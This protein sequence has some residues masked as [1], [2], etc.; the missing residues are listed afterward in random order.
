MG[1]RSPYSSLQ[2]VHD[3]LT[4]YLLMYS[5]DGALLGGLRYAYLCEKRKFSRVLNA[6]SSIH[7]HGYGMALYTTGLSVLSKRNAMLSPDAGSVI[8]SASHIWTRLWEHPIIK[9]RPLP[10]AYQEDNYN[11]LSSKELHVSNP[12]IPERLLNK[13]VDG[14]PQRLREF[15]H[16]EELNP[17]P[18]NYGY[19]MLTDDAEYHLSI[20]NIEFSTVTLEDIFEFENL[21]GRH[22]IATAKA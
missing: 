3:D 21:W 15:I 16:Q 13:I 2:F 1:L 8:D 7:G 10:V 19:H 20:V 14:D 5:V 4:G 17:H 18:F 22:Y 9:K 12:D 11:L 6:L